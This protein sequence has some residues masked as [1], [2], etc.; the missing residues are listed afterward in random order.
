MTTFR[1]AI[2]RWEN[3]FS[4]KMLGYSTLTRKARNGPDEIFSIARWDNDA[5]S[6]NFIAFDIGL[7][8]IKGRWIVDERKLKTAIREKILAAEESNNLGITNITINYPY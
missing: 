8:K 2:S 5:K 3:L 1:D 7:K 6:F 4:E